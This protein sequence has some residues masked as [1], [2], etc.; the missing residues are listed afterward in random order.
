MYT[1]TQENPI[2]PIPSDR[3]SAQIDG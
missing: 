3:I 2:Q 1:V